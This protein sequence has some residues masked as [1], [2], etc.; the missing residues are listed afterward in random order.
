MS[1]GTDLLADVFTDHSPYHF[2]YNNPISF[3]DP[4]GLH[5]DPAR[6]TGTIGNGGYLEMIDDYDGWAIVIE[7]T[8][9]NLP[10]PEHT[11][12]FIDHSGSYGSG[13]GGSGGG[14]GGSRSGSGS[15]NSGPREASNGFSPSEI[16]T[17]T[18]VGSVFANGLEGRAN[19]NVNHKYKYGSNTHTAKELTDLNKARM[20]NI[21]KG[22]NVLGR[23]VG[24]TGAAI[25]VYDA[26]ENPTTANIIKASANVGL[27]FVRMNP[28][29]GVILGISDLSGF[30][31][32][33]YNGVGN[34][35]DNY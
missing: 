20:N 7:I 23:A 35:I 3:M 8:Q 34:I 12:E 18:T 24:V 11:V 25:A 16:S 21:A 5:N 6:P 26:F 4:T 31:D 30:N 2:G 15:G 19:E 10:I 28:V 22:A 13:G 32:F 17:L 1:F 27:L 14:C 9:P 33:I 29:T